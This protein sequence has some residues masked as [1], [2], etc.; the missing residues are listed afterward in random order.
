[1]EMHESD[2][3][4]Q[5][6][7]FRQLIPLAL[8]DLDDLYDF[9]ATREP[10]F[11]P[12]LAYYLEYMPWFRVHGKPYLLGGEARAKPPHAR[13]PQWA[14]RN[15]KREGHNKADEVGPSSTLT[16]EL[17]LMVAPPLD[18]AYRPLSLTY[19]MP[20]PLTFPM[21]TMPMT[22]YKPSTYVPKSCLDHYAS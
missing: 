21:T 17:T 14:P 12:E 22:T 18:F 11:T 8:Q 5:Q 20:M 16:Q 15:P 6:F 19:Y 7:G 4:L 3:V 9:L 2:R 13:R 1:M 10:I